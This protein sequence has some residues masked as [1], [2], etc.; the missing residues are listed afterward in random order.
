MKKD[1]IDKHE[2]KNWNLSPLI[3]AQ[4][5]VYI[6]KVDT[7]VFQYFHYQRMR[8]LLKMS[9]KG[10]K[11][12]VDRSHI[13]CQTGDNISILPNVTW[14]GGHTKTYNSLDIFTLYSSVHKADYLTDKNTWL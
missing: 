10:W 12:K 11:Q 7:D 6:L 13:I 3:A 14:Y 9:K 1:F 4:E 8:C 5:S 2:S